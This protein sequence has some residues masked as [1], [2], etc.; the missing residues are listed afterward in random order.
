MV[1]SPQERSRHFDA[2]DRPSDQ[3]HPSQRRTIGEGLRRGR[4]WIRVVLR[5]ARSESPRRGDHRARRRHGS[6]GQSGAPRRAHELFEMS[7]PADLPVKPDFRGVLLR[8]GMFILIGGLSL[9]AF[10]V[11][12]SNFLAP[13]VNSMISTFAA[14][15]LANSVTVRIYERGRLADVG[16]GWAKRSPTEFL[17]GLGLGVIAP[18]VILGD[19]SAAAAARFEASAPVEHRAAT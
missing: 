7:K 6:A 16:L 3:D 1:A 13:D 2:V 11:A 18:V 15:A 4:R 5:R 8:I 19:A 10:S 12:L 17:W 14:A 9:V